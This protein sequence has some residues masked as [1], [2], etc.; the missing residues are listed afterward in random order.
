MLLCWMLLVTADS[1]NLVTIF[2]PVQHAGTY[3]HTN[4]CA[5]G[6]LIPWELVNLLFFP[7]TME[8]T[9]PFKAGLFAS[10]PKYRGNPNYESHQI[11]HQKENQVRTTHLS[12]LQGGKGNHLTYVYLFKGKY[13]N[14]KHNRQQWNQVTNLVSSFLW[15]IFLDSQ[16][17]SKYS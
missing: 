13:R 4:A 6:L 7:T 9:G 5:Q 17:S 1:H 8:K 14:Y 12:N 11:L 2:L 3:A 16:K 15:I 10:N